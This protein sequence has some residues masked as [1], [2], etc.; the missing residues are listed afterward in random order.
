[1]VSVLLVLL[2]GLHPME[3][4]VLNVP[5]AKTLIQVVNVEIVLQ[6][7]L[8]HWEDCVLLVLMDIPLIQEEIVFLALQELTR[9]LVVFVWIVLLAIVVLLLLEN[10]SLVVL[11]KHL[12]KE[13]NV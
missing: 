1:L 4:F 8:L 6:D 5:L 9:S 3:E 12:L 2:V 13:V 7:I 10:V 11:A